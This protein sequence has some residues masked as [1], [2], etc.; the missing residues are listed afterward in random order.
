MEPVGVSCGGEHTLLL[1]RDTGE[2]FSTG[3]CGLGWEGRQPCAQEQATLNRRARPCLVSK[4]FA[5]VHGAAAG[6]P[7]EPIQ[8]AVGG[9]YHSLAI[10]RA[11]RLYSWGCGN[12]EGTN[13]GQLGQG[14]GK[15]DNTLPA[16]VTVPGLVDGERVVD[17]A[18]GCYH[19]AVLTSNQRVFTFGLNNYGQ[20]GRSGLAAGAAVPRSPPTLTANNDG[21][22]GDS[23][24][25][26]A[27]GIPRAVEDSPSTGD[28]A[29]G[30]VAG[31][32]AGFY[33][34]YLLSRSGEMRCA[35]SNAAGQCG[36]AS[37]TTEAPAAVPELSGV[38]VRQA[39]GGYCHTLVLDANGTVFSMGCGED[40]QRG[41]GRPLD[42]DLVPECE[43]EAHEEAVENYK[44][45]VIT[46][47]AMPGSATTIS[48]VA[49]GANHSLAV[50]ATGQLF[51][52][53]SNEHGQLTAALP[54]DGVSTPR[55][56]PLPLDRT[57]GER[58]TQV[59]A[60]YAHTAVVTNTGRTI[61]FGKGENGQL[62]HGM[63]VDDAEPVALNFA[64][65]SPCC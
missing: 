34:L 37:T 23:A 38:Q 8:K 52:W 46:S 28:S 49:A 14:P 31:I 55:H 6:L 33:T 30:L 19:S 16:L 44:P 61:L 48:S 7:L 59:S 20:L 25:D 43:R 47:C 13:D 45:T 60:G 62:G 42:G 10:S 32:G 18:A 21:S 63:A 4:F 56:L 53:G 57:I 22:T 58:V 2:L 64:S 12:F 39:V 41:D 29:D 5:A 9:Y 17:A 36:T 54:E 35:G 51:G 1:S 27:D 40:G 24:D 11:G 3:A 26:Y 50:S 15:E 65:V